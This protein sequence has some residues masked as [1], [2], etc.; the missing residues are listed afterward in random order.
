MKI[1]LD[2]VNLGS[3]DGGM[4]R[5]AR[6]LIAAIS[7]NDRLDQCLIFLNAAVS[8]EI[9]IEDKRF[10]KIV[11]PVRRRKYVPVNQM[12]FAMA[13]R[14]KGLDFLHSPVSVSPL[15]CRVKTVLTVHDLAFEHFPQYY[16]RL[17]VFYW[18]FAYRWACRRAT[19]VLADSESTKRDLVRCM[20]VPEEKIRVV[21]PF[22]TMGN[23]AFSPE[24]LDALRTRYNLPERFILH[25]G[26]PHARKNLATLVR[27]FQ[28][29]KQ[30]G[31]IPHKLVLV[32]PEGWS[33]DSLRANIADSGM[34]DE[35]VLTGLIPDDDLPLMYQAA[36]ALVF[37]SM[38]EGFGY[39]PLEAMACGTP[40]IVS[41]SSSL[42]EVVGE[43]GLYADP[44][45]PQDFAEKIM[46]LLTN[47]ELAHR[48]KGLAVEQAQRFSKDRMAASLAGVYSEV[49]SGDS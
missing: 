12:Y 25:V 33:F 4:G 29:I 11:V 46:Q 36:D 27:A 26:V 15:L 44:L 40:V 43:A 32:G 19:R 49:L 45:D 14:V 28:I 38:Y 8:D 48:L 16:T 10:H 39:P 24:K 42:P 13:N 9:Q 23:G 35:V 6:Q 3:V 31:A 20:N 7:A 17:G 34:G 41:N 37:P 2:L 22:V 47:H 5:Y 1:G 30:N 18:R 21:Y